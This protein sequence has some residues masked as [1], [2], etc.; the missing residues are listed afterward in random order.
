MNIKIQ[1]VNDEKI[2]SDSVAIFLRNYGFQVHQSFDGQAAIRDFTSFSPDIILLDSILPDIRGNVLCEKLKKAMDVG[3]IFLTALSDKANI[4]NAFNS[5][6]DDYITKP[7]DMDILLSRISALSKRMKL[8]AEDFSSEKI[9][10]INSLE[11]NM[12][13]TDV[14][15][16]GNYANLTPIEFKILYFLSTRNVFCT[17]HE[18]LELLYGTNSSEVQSRTISVHISNI[19]KKLR[20]IHLKDIKISSR[21]NKGYRLEITD[22]NLHSVK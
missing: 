14:V 8:Q 13:K 6:A 12:Y 7:F 22:H 3:V 15:Y 5:G 2:L 4:L 10:I 20:K 17:K 18:I 9:Q 1:I 11:F 21:Y 19:R 16:E